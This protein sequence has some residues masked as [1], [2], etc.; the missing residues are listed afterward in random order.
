[1]GGLDLV[2]P[3]RLTPTQRIFLWTSLSYVACLLKCLHNFFIPSFLI[4]ILFFSVFGGCVNIIICL[5]YCFTLQHSPPPSSH[6]GPGRSDLNKITSPPTHHLFFLYCIILFLSIQHHALLLEST[7]RIHVFIFIEVKKRVFWWINM[8][9]SSFYKV[10]Q[11]LPIL[12][13]KPALCFYLIP[14]W[15]FGN[16]VLW[17][18]DLQFA[19]GMGACFRNWYNCASIVAHWNFFHRRRKLCRVI[20]EPPMCIAGPRRSSLGVPG[21][22]AKRKLMRRLCPVSDWPRA[23]MGT[24][25]YTTH[26]WPY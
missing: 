6:C 3:Y 16:D 22:S 17:G 1:M 15:S 9:I 12:F 13:E 5:S 14:P 11:N 25:I 23:L 26:C 10:Q 24:R 18:I 19:P 4:C 2:P 8:L 7:G 20:S 21:H